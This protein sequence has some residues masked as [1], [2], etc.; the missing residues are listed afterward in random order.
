MAR[1]DQTRVT[2]TDC[3]ELELGK[4]LIECRQRNENKQKWVNIKLYDNLIVCFIGF[5]LIT[6]I[7]NGKYQAVQQF[8]SVLY[9]I[10]TN[11]K[12]FKR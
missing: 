3:K 12:H 8:N 11:Y 1:H 7:F 2:N 10:F 9:W 4:V 5:S 6:N